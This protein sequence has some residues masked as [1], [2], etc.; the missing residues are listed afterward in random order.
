ME[1]EVIPFEPRAGPTRTPFDRFADERARMMAAFRAWL[2]TDPPPD[3]VVEEIAATAVALEQF[4][5]LAWG[6]KA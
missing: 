2:A 3:D 1:A 6:N 4:R 5:Q